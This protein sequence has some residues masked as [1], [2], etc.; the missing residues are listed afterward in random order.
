MVVS[1]DDTRPRI[2][3]YW[4]MDFSRKSRARG[5]ELEHEYEELLVDATRIRLRSDVPIGLTFSGGVDSGSIAWA[6]AKRLDTPLHLLHDRLRHTRAPQPGDQQ[7][8]RGGG[9]ARAALE[10]HPVRPPHRSATRLSPSYR[11]YDEPCQ[12][13]ALVY[14]DRLYRE[15]RQFATVVL[16]GNGADEL[17]TGYDG[18]QRQRQ[19]DLLGTAFRWLRPALRSERLPDFLRMDPDEAHRDALLA[20]AEADGGPALRERVEPAAERIAERARES[21]VRTWLDYLMFIALTCA[22]RDTTTASPTSRG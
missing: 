22:T 9:I 2:D 11:Y 15:I 3:R 12:Q 4:R 1:A 7:R 19:R 18:D 17:F 16:S 20:H 13:L 14:S 5:R 6:C 21:E 8:A 10:A